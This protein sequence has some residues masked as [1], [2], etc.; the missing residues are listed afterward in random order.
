MDPPHGLMALK[1]SEQP[2][3]NASVSSSAVEPLLYDRLK[4]KRSLPARTLR[5]P[6]DS[7]RSLMY[8]RKSTTRPL[9]AGQLRMSLEVLLLES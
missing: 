9:H 6:V 7:Q 5:Q 3:S 1:T 4:C 2:P 8:G